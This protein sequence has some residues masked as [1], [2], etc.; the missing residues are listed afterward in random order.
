MYI[1]LLVCSCMEEQHVAKCAGTEKSNQIK[2]AWLTSVTRTHQGN[3]KHEYL[4][5]RKQI[6]GTLRDILLTC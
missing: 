2:S 4:P 3:F 5:G 6:P 1:R